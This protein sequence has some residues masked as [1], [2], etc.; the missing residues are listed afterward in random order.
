MAT[1][2]LKN[3]FWL[4]PFGR[5]DW[6]GQHYKTARNQSN[7]V[8]GEKHV[9]GKSMISDIK[10]NKEKIL[11]FHREMSDLGMQKKTKI[12]KL[13]DDVQH[14]KAV[15][16]GLSRNEWRGTYHEANTVPKSYSTTQEAARR[17]VSFLVAQDGT[18]G[19]VSV[20]E[21]IICHFK[22]RNCLLTLRQVLN[23]SPLLNLLN[24]TI[25]L[26]IRSSIVTKQDSTFACC[27]IRHWLHPLKDQQ[28][29]GKK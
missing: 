20:T 21:S 16:C 19:S 1:I 27:Q 17:P 18:G 24:N 25:L 22:V 14:D 13:G 15:F 2:G 6:Q 5:E 3:A 11:T 4:C 10:E 9:A 8:V 26:S 28:M 7:K 29:G 23:S 12:M